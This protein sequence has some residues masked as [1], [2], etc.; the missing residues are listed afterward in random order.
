MVHIAVG[1]TMFYFLFPFSSIY[2]LLYLLYFYFALFFVTQYV[3]VLLF[4]FNFIAEDDDV[5]PYQVIS[6]S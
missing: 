4:I 1:A 5:G 6:D 2:L 3:Y